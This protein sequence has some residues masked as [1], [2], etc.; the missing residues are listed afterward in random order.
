[1]P[2]DS[3]K[4]TGSNARRS[5]VGGFE[6]VSKLGQGGMGAVF[7]AIQVSVARPIAL[8]ILPQRLAK[9]PDYLARFF[10]EARS[11]A[12][13]NHPN[14]VQAIDA[15]EADGY[16]Y[17]AME[18]VDGRSLAD[19]L[20]AGKPLAEMDYAHQAGIIHRDIKPA[21][22]LLTASGQPKLADLGLARQ[23]A[24]GASDLTQAGFALGT[25]DY[26]SPEQVRGDADIDGRADI[27]SLGATL[28]HLLTG[29]PPYAGGTG[30]E[31]MA[32]H[33]AESLPDPRQSNPAVSRSTARI[34]WK[35]M[36][37]NRDQRY[38]SAGDMASDI[39]RVMAG[40]GD[41]ARPSRARG[42]RPVRSKSRV[43][44]IF[45]GT[46]AAVLVAIAVVVATW[47]PSPEGDPRVTP[48]PTSPP[49]QVENRT[50]PEASADEEALQFLRQWVQDHPGEY[51]RALEMY[52]SAIRRMTHSA[53]E[54]VAKV[55]FAAMAGQI[56][57][58]RA[59]L[60]KEKADVEGLARKQALAARRCRGRGPGATGSGEP[61]AERRVGGC[62]GRLRQ[63]P[64]R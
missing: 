49:A 10:R 21:N 24:G 37:K 1:M 52:G 33:L 4:P 55:Q 15:G 19:V 58:M 64:A 14:I 26:I 11:A 36:A 41:D 3:E 63:G 35:A 22:I 17:F 7:K 46:L 20:A 8:K 57:S 6:V 23:A 16:H 28:F 30:N 56:S 13:L 5:R 18:F 27:Y 47:E 32:K 12:R 44:M 25:P 60:K 62:R 43:P 48:P 31:V 34:I 9:N 2:S 61:A 50:P 42:S 38:R 29:Q 40:G 53:L 45:G 51:R 54:Q 59:R 39:E